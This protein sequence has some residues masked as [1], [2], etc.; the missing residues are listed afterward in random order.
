[1]Y[2]LLM[3][4]LVV[5]LCVGLAALA[6][7]SS[8]GKSDSRPPQQGQNSA[9]VKGPLVGK[10]LFGNKPV[11][12]GV[13]RKVKALMTQAEVKSLFPASIPTPN[14]SASPSLTIESGFSDARYDIGFYF[15][16]DQ[17][18]AVSV[19]VPRMKI[20]EHLKQAWGKPA[21]DD[22]RPSTS[23]Q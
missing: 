12:P 1:M 6:V 16:L 23:R 9:A 5:A 7:Q 3:K 20:E 4:H 13:L 2:S 21:S 11:P 14:Q 19:S 15:D 22:V 8:C 18:S 10:E 17:V